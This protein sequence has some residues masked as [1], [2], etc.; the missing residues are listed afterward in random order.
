MLDMKRT[1]I[2][3]D[4]PRLPHAHEVSDAVSVML[5]LGGAVQLR[6]RII[7][8]LLNDYFTSEA[9]SSDMLAFVSSLQEADRRQKLEEPLMQMA[10]TTPAADAIADSA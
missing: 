1:N 6:L 10:Q 5:N 3:E 7:H 8:L 9:M 2:P 4:S